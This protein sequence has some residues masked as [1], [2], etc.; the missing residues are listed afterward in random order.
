MRQEL[1]IAP[2]K[3]GLV[4]SLTTSD[5]GL[6]EDD[7]LSRLVISNSDLLLAEK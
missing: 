1:L 5:N 2:S 3:G 6:S 4:S 7:I